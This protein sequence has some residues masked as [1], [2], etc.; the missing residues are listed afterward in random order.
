MTAE[1]AGVIGW[2]VSHS[3]SPRM[4][5]FW[6]REH[7]IA[8][9]YVALPVRRHRLSESLAGLQAAGF[10]GVNVTLPHKQAVFALAHVADADARAV[11]AANL[12]LLRDDRFA[13]FN[14]DVDGLVQSLQNQMLDKS[15]FERAVVLGA[16]G[17]ARAAVF[18]CGRLQAKEI[19]VVN[20]T[21]A[22][23]ETL[24]RAMSRSVSGT[25]TTATW[26]AW[27]SL[28]G[29][30]RL[31]VNATSAGLN[32]TSSPE[33]PLGLL[34]DDAV[35]CDLVY[36][37]LETPLLAAARA[38]GLVTIDGLGMLMHQGAR[39]FE[40]LFGIRPAVSAALRA[41]LEQTLRDEQ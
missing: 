3:L 32:G 28:A 23:A 40:L 21:K 20:R 34:P 26:G 8:G 41:C 33:F 38:R 9:A 6:M 37:P 29:N 39:A 19:C 4:H 13:V 1:L 25:L 30:T 31:L 36:K 14:T 16:G 15:G 7:G 2:P 22:H 5:E 24:V 27:D 17:A 35:V 12:V 11:E 10:A 18:A